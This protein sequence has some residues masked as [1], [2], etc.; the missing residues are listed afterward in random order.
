MHHLGGGPTP[1][2]RLEGTLDACPALA[3]WT[4]QGGGQGMGAAGQ[5]G[6]DTPGKLAS[7]C[8]AAPQLWLEP[9]GSRCEGASRA[10]DPHTVVVALC[11]DRAPL[12]YLLVPAPTL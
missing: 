3:F 5:K 2:S 4:R 9:P 6:Q 8:S 1:Q 11:W 12:G 10:W 7:S